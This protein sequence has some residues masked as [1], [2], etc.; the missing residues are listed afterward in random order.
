MNVVFN[1][2]DAPFCAQV[3]QVIKMIYV[4]GKGSE[5]DPVRSVVEYL[6]LEGER[7]VKIDPANDK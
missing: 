2:Q 7:I 5:E 3:V 1:P 4:V 6:T